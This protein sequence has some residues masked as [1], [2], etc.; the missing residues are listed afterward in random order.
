MSQEQTAVT[1]QKLQA[2]WHW[3]VVPVLTHITVISG[4]NGTTAFCYASTKIH[5]NTRDFFVVTVM[6]TGLI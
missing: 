6:Q 4:G 3:H 5:Y 1:R 2:P